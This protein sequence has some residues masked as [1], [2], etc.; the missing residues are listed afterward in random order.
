MAEQQT[1]GSIVQV[2]GVVVDVQ[3]PEGKVPMLYEALHVVS[4]YT[5]GKMLVLEVASHLGDDRILG[6]ST[7]PYRWPQTR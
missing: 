4:A 5:A 7:G 2:I 3:F 6:G 1:K